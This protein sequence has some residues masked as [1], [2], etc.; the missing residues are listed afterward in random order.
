MAVGVGGAGIVCEALEQLAL[1]SLALAVAAAVARDG[2]AAGC[3]AGGVGGA[4]AGAA[5]AAA[6]CV[7]VA[8]Q[9][10]H[11]GCCGGVEHGGSHDRGGAESN[12]VLD[13]LQGPL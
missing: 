1:P 12:T 13:G 10:L 8:A 6:G 7:V 4:G 2:A 5:A 11:I 3:A 9:M